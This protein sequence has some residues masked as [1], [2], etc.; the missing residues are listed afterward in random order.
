[1]QQS[2]SGYIMANSPATDYRYSGH[3]RHNETTPAAAEPQ[4]AAT[5]PSA[6]IYIR[7]DRERQ[8]ALG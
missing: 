6:L 5:A 2:T 1:M 8:D 4:S 7:L 3:Q